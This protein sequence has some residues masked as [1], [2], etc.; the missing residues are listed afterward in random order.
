MIRSTQ[1]FVQAKADHK[2]GAARETLHGTGGTY[3]KDTVYGANDG[4]VT[5]FAVVAGVAGAN[6]PPTVVIV[7]GFANLLADGFSMALGNYLGTKSE[8]EYAQEERS[9]EAWEIDN[10]PKEE[11][12]EIREIYHQKGFRGKDLETAVNIITSDKNRWVNEM[13]IHELGILPQDTQAPVKNALV[14]FTAFVIAGLMPLIP[15][16]FSS[17]VPQFSILHFQFSILF[18]AITLFAVGSART[19]ITRK[20]WWQSGLEMLLIGAIASGIAFAVGYF[21]DQIIN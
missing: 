10:L 3:I 16:L 18:T 20:V 21:L 8:Q 19:L 15:Y 5:T 7:L 6:L 4:I 9:S 2:S 13:M 1:H 12:R 14:T 17:P 11:T